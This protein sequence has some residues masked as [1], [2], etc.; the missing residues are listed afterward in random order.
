LDVALGQKEMASRMVLG[1]AERREVLRRQAEDT[2]HLARKAMARAYDQRHAPIPVFESG[3]AFLKLG[4]GYSLPG[5]N[6]L[7]LAPQKIGPFRILSVHG[8]GRAFALQFPKHFTIHNVISVAH[9]EPAPTPEEDP[10]H[11]QLSVDLLSPVVGLP[12]DEDV[13]WQVE[14]ILDKRQQKS[15]PIE[16]LVRWKGVG[17][18]YDRWMPRRDLGDAKD[19]VMAYDKENRRP[20]VRKEKGGA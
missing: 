14:A 6:K 10:W 16:Y 15:K 3:W 8:K 12:N 13:T 18:E 17:A 4:N 7:K 5:I 19:L 20:R 11:R 1:I 2:V 9:L